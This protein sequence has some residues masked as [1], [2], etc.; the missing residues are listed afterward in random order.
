MANTKK[1]IYSVRLKMSEE[2]YKWFEF[3]DYDDF[4]NWLGYCVHG[5]QVVDLAIAREEVAHE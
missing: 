5:T 1:Y 4:Q 2:S 3:D